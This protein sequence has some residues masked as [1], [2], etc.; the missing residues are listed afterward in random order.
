M[1]RGSSRAPS[2]ARC[3]VRRSCSRP[4]APM[5]TRSTRGAMA[6]PA[7]ACSRLST[8][9]LPPVPGIADASRGTSGAN[10]RY[11][12]ASATGGWRRLWLGGRPG[13]ESVAGGVVGPYSA[14]LVRRQ[15]PWESTFADQP[16]SPLPTPALGLAVAATLDGCGAHRDL[17]AWADA[18]V[19]DPHAGRGLGHV[20]ARPLAGAAHQRR[21]LQREGAAAVLADPCGLGHVWRQRRLAAR[22]RGAVWRRRTGAADGVGAA[23]VSHTRL[24]GAG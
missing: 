17:L 6:A 19:F 7:S 12:T 5:A 14:T 13:C 16:L 4:F 20:G 22:P 1:S 3:S 2:N 9:S 15:R 24:G 8:A 10:S 11:A 23:P 18:A 21:P